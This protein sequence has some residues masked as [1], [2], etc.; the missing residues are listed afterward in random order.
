MVVSA[1][2]LYAQQSADEQAVWKQEHAYWKYVQAGDMTD[3]SSLWNAKFVGWPSSSAEPAHKSQ[4]TNWI[5]A[6]T[7][8]GRHLKSYELKQADSQS[9]GNIVLTYYWITTDWADKDGHEER[10]TAR[11]THTWMRVG[12]GWQIIGGMSCKE[13]LTTH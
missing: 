12:D 3:Y 5:T 2:S 4:I 9:H 11:I 8:K 10:Q 1:C 7:A 6:Y 13:P